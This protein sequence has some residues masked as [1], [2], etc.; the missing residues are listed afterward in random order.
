MDRSVVIAMKRRAASES[1]AP[2]RRKQ[3]DA[4]APLHRKC[5]RW[6]L[7]N[8][9]QL[10]GAE[11]VPV[12]GLDDRAVDNWEAL[13]A[14]ADAAGNAW[15]ERARTAAH[16][17]SAADRGQQGDALGEQLLSDVRR[18]FEENGADAI[19]AKELLER[20]LAMEE[21]PWAEA[22]RGRPLTPRGLGTRLGRFEISSRTVRLGSATPRCYVRADFEDAFGRYLAVPPVTTVTAP[23][24]SVRRLNAEESQLRLVTEAEEARQSGERQQVTDVTDG[25]DADEAAYAALERAAIEEFGS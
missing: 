18:V 16:V 22:Q 9:E 12:S 14:I 11:P 4:L 20:L 3:R 13:L 8:L 6:A 25:F 23:E 19:P 7:D 17:L 24:S 21:R 15:P 5:M 2:F 1:V 10:R